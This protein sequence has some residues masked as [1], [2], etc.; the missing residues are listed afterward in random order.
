[1]SG[2]LVRERG[3]SWTRSL[4]PGQRHYGEF[5]RRFQG[6]EYRSWNGRRSKL[7]A[8]LEKG[9]Q[10]RLH[11]NEHV[12]YLGAA[13]GT[14]VS[15]LSDLLPDGRILAVEM[16]PRPFRDL[17]QLAV[18]RPNI[19]PI[20][21]DARHPEAYE[22]YVDR[23]ADVLVQDIAQPDQAEILRRNVVRFAGPEA[24]TY[25]AV[26]AR[27]VN[28]AAA[29]AKIYEAV[30]SELRKGG[31]HVEDRRELDPLERDHAM[32]VVTASAKKATP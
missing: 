23:P 21:G 9:G 24:T 29:P 26:K 31:L 12:L 13:S 19:V 5:L 2:R 15:H 6:A 14:T 4:V 25:F 3:R 22:A 28:V 18:T 1:M 20:L 30:A 27:S 32:F 11:G 8:Y 7:A 17:L 16:S 10:I